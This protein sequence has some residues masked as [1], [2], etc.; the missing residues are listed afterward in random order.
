M[1]FGVVGATGEYR[2]RTVAPAVLIAPDRLRL[3][4]ARAL[5]YAVTAAGVALVMLPWSRSPSASR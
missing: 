4:L 5:A 3:L 2:H 1:V